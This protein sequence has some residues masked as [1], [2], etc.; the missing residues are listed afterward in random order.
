MIGK[1]LEIML[2]RVEFKA[3]RRTVVDGEFK[4]RAST[5]RMRP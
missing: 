4:P 2:R 1:A 3:S 5:Q